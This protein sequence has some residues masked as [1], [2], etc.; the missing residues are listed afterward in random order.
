MTLV[1]QP[2]ASQEKLI[3]ND[4]E[5]EMEYHE[6]M[7]KYYLPFQHFMMVLSLVGV[8]SA[9][10]ALSVRLESFAKKPFS[11][12][13]V[14]FCFPTLSHA[15]AIQ[16]YRGTVAAFSNFPP[17][18]HF[19]TIL[20]GYWMVF[21]FIGTA[22][23]VIFTAKYIHHLPQWTGLDTSDEEEPPAP[24]HTFVH[25]LLN[26][27]ETHELL[28]QPFTSPAVLQANE[29]GALVRVRRDSA[30]YRLH[31]PYV[32]TR[33]VPALGFDP[34]LTDE[35]LKRERAELLNWVATNAPRRRHRTM[36]NPTFLQD[37]GPSVGV[38][39]TFGGNARHQRSAT[40][41]NVPGV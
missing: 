30:D 39:G 15:N 10:S 9:V 17:G 12:A 6:W 25:D 37:S 24:E 20:Y 27:T 21:L 36:S 28:D 26:L 40:T 31:G 5:D 8:L 1:A 35:E 13:H 4:K 32:R 41:T 19:R 33:K 2:S 7:A 14:A 3:E 11:P 18:G 29:A 16:A 23:N 22:V 34:T 38:Y